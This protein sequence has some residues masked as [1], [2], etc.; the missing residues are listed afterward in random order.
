MEWTG[1]TKT[2]EGA[3]IDIFSVFVLSLVSYHNSDL[4]IRFYAV[5]FLNARWFYIAFLCISQGSATQCI[6]SMAVV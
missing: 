1:S 2:H 4:C 3:A 5:P 6:R